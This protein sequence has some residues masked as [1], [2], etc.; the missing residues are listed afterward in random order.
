MQFQSDLTGAQIDVCDS[1]STVLGAIFMAGLATGAFTGLDDIAK[2]IQVFKI[3]TPQSNRTDIR[4]ILDG[5]HAAIK[6]CL[7]K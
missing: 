2:R 5:W 6:Q 1:E 3:Y 7:N 4:H